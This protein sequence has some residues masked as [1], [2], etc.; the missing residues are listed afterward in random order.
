M[1]GIRVNEKLCTYLIRRFSSAFQGHPT[2][3]SDNKYTWKI[4]KFIDS[5][6]DHNSA[7][8]LQK[9]KCAA[10]ETSKGKK[11]KPPYRPPSS[12]DIARR[13]PFRS[14]LSFDFQ[15]SYTETPKVAPLGFREPKFSPFGPGR[16]D[17]E[18]TGWCAPSKSIV[19][20]S[21]EGNEESTFDLPKGRR[22]EEILGAPLTKEEIQV[23]VD[24]NRPQK[25]RRVIHLETG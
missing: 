17:R 23:L 14:D 22:R 9:S 6:E 1:A 19:V 24:E 21:I 16:L 11:E 10:R 3:P 8:K 4:P 13:K 18:W 2:P 25:T 12:L 5:D 15:F 20:S 7:T